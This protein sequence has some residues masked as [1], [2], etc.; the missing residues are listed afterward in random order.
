[1]PIYKSPL[2]QSNTI[3]NETGYQKPNDYAFDTSRITKK[4]TREWGPE[5]DNRRL[6]RMTADDYYKLAANEVGLKW[7]DLQDQR[8]SV[9]NQIS[10]ADMADLMRKGEKFPTPWI[11]LNN[12]LGMIPH[13]Q[14]GLHRML[15]AKD[16]Y[17]D[18]ARFPVYLGFE[19]DAPYNDI[20]EAL[21]KGTISDFIK[22]MNA[23]R[24]QRQTDYDNEQWEKEQKQKEEDRKLARLWFGLNGQR[25]V[26]DEELD[27]Y[28]RETDRLFEGDD[29]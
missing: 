3:L 10:V 11:H 21:E 6:V 1:M 20:E 2:E 28:Y 19:K 24:L 16:V 8:R 12:R 25:D 5:F 17:G 7:Q 14:E 22:K 4:G 26:T 15:A 18:K 29:Y 13:F 23:D 27:R 9:P